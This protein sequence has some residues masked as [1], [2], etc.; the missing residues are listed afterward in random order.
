MFVDQL[1][2]LRHA[3][4]FEPFLHLFKDL[5]I[6][7]RFVLAIVNVRL[8]GDFSDVQSVGQQ[9]MNGTPAEITTAAKL[10]FASPP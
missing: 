2:S 5:G 9:R 8:V 10:P 3:V 1:T 6:D 7:N 4:R